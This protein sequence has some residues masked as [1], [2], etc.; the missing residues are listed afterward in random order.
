MFP[1]PFF[2]KSQDFVTWQLRKTLERWLHILTLCRPK[3]EKK[4][5]VHKNSWN[6]VFTRIIDAPPASVVKSCIINA[7]LSFE[8][9]QSCKRP[10]C[11]IPTSLSPA[12]LVSRCSGTVWRSNSK[13]P[14]PDETATCCHVRAAVTFT[15]TLH[16][17]ML[18]QSFHTARCGVLTCMLYRLAHQA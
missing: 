1:I 9:L 12:S 14:L 4:A 10:R 6:T 8:S 17:S 3:Q 2:L 16:S 18:S 11:G 7:L 13:L 15:H 5:S